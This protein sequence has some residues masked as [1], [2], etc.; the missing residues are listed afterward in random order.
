[1]ETQIIT[2]ESSL[3]LP[4]E[5]WSEIH[6]DIIL[7]ASGL[8]KKA[9]NVDA[10]VASLDNILRTS[11]AE[12]V[13]LPNFGA[14]LSNLLFEPVSES[15]ATEITSKIK[16]AINVWDD[17]ILINSVDFS[18]IPDRNFV[19]FSMSFSIVGYNKVFEY[20]M[21]APVGG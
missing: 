10:V 12:R 21:E 19:S 5:V 11:P 13:M 14:G 17:R 3:I 9:I 8:I 15:T 7:D 6:Q 20:S 18:A 4:G 16:E 1:M 2:E